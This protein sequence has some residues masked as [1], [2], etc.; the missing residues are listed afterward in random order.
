MV[1]NILMYHYVRNN[2]EYEY[3]TFCRR[4]NEF[5]SQIEFFEKTSS[6]VNCNDLEKIKYFLNNEQES[7]YLLTFDDGYKDHLFCA[8]Y[9]YEKELNAF[10]FPPSQ[11]LNGNILDVNAIHMLIGKRG[12]EIKEI[13]DLIYELCTIFKYKLSLNNQKIDIKSYLENFNTTNNYDNRNTLILKRILQKDLI[14]EKNRKRIINILLEKFICKKQS[15]LA[16][17]LYLNKKDLIKMKNKGMSFGSHGDTHRW[18][19]NL[20][21]LEQ[22]EEVENSL[23]FLKDFYLISDKD[24]I[25]ISFPFGGYDFNTI[26]I[27]RKL[28]ID[29]GFSTDI[30]PAKFKEDKDFIFK[31][32]RWDTNHF[33]DNKWRR[34]CLPK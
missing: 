2:E 16:S 26:K 31:L 34:P 4:K 33:W 6:I 13:L 9:L 25:S 12:I 28:N 8:N 11:I 23:L 15:D 7:A 3:D 27:M 14:G 17:E 1:I 19:N 32:P 30:G 10:F 29:L 22:K 18:L 24:P 20:N 5:V 21:F